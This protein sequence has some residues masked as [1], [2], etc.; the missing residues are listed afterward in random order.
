[1]CLLIICLKFS[2]LLKTKFLYLMGQ[3]SAG[4]QD[5]VFASFSHNE[6]KERRERDIRQLS[7]DI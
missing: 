4:Y 7:E 1:M 5:V 3:N 6:G 2:I